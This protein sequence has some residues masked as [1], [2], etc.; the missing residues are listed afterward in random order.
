LGAK[1]T[2][3][4]VNWQGKVMPHGAKLWMIGTDTAKDYLSARYGLVAGPGA[5]HFPADLPTEYYEQL[6]AE[7]CI[8][9]YK[10]GRKVRVWEKKKNDRNEAGD[11]MVYAIACAHYLGLH[12]KTPAQWK[13]VREFVDPDT[14]DLFQDPAPATQADA[15]AAPQPPT[16][17][18][19]QNN[20]WPTSKPQTSSAPRRPQGRQW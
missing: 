19:P 16:S 4:D 8:T 3:V 10:R 1:P 12:K 14:R 15:P 2:L 6:T 11:L 5:I 20:P 17:T 9:V 7:Y 18:Q 13:Q